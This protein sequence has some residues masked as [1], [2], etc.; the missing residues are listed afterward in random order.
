L[1]SSLQTLG[2]RE[3]GSTEGAFARASHSFVGLL[4]AEGFFV[5]DNAKF[6]CMKAEFS[7]FSV[8]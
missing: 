8:I 4:L 5:M 6:I 1:K 7:K 3:K 2:T